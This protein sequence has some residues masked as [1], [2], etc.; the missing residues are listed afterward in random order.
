MEL[1]AFPGSWGVYRSAGCEMPCL[2]AQTGGN[3]PMETEA[4][5]WKL[6]LAYDGTDFH[7]WQV[8]PDRITV[9]GLLRDALARI[10]GEEVLPQGSG[11]TDAGV[12][13]LGQ[14]ASF[15]LVAPIP[16][17][18]LVRALNRILPAAIRVLSAARVAND[19]H[20]RHSARA[21]T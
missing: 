19:F 16:E 5:M 3:L 1:P 6:V 18:N 7:G 21:K 8:Q 2:R 20:A 13:A 14:V 9:Q 10:T 4:H 12:H 15:A 17:E 11:R